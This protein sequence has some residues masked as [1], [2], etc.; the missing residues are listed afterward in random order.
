MAQEGIRNT[1]RKTISNIPFLEQLVLKP[2]R[3]FRLHRYY[4]SLLPLHELDEATRKMWLERIEKVKKSSDNQRIHKISGAGKLKN[5][6]LVMHNGLV[7]DPLS[8]YGA[9]VMRMLMENDAVHEPQEEYVFQ[10]VLKYIPEKA[11]MLEV[12]CYWGFYSMWFATKV[13]GARNFLTDNQDGIARAQ[14]NFN[15]NRLKAKFMTG[16]IGKDNPGSPIPIT[17]VD[18]ICRDNNISYLDIMHA[19]IQGFELEMLETM[20]E[21]LQ[22]KAIGFFFIS[23]HS[24]ELHYG[25][26]EYLKSKGYLILCHADLNDSFSE[27]GLIVARNPAYPG[28]DSFDISQLSQIKN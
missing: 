22:K 28:P 20:P 1:I 9:P 24:Q 7:I 17:N 26:I 23:T 12:G 2:W 19:D 25:C 16:Y 18:K 4:Q 3:T 10:E 21:M 15:M 13:K 11:T 5:G 8:Y 14:A 6:K 27:D